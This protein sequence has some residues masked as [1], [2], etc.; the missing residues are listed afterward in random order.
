MNP[1]RR[2]A[3][4]TGGAALLSAVAVDTLAVVGRNI[5]IPILGSI[6]LVQAAVLVSGVFALILATAGDQ[7]ARVRLLSDR[8]A[9]WR[10]FA[11]LVGPVCLAAFFAA[12]LVGSAWLAADLWE[13]HERSEVLGLSWR[14]L[15]VV[16]NLGLGACVVVALATPF[17]RKRP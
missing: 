13:G 7:H 2:I 3:I 17:L 11:N 9:A 16:A 1:L 14:T 6:E 15:R 8:F 4:W 5:G 12:L 10:S